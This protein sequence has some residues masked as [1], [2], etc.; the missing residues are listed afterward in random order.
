MPPTIRLHRTS[1]MSHRRL[2]DGLRL[3]I[4]AQSSGGQAVVLAGRLQV[5]PGIDQSD[6]HLL[7]AEG[8]RRHVSGQLSEPGL[9][10]Y[11]QQ[12]A[13]S[14]RQRPGVRHLW[15]RSAVP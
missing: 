10:F 7:S 9:L 5:L 14:G 4:S 11:P 1:W 6:L 13:V 2:L 12:V 15:R 8:C 3:P